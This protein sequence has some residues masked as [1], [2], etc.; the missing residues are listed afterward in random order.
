[1]T[2][3]EREIQ[4]GAEN[5][6]AR[7]RHCFVS[8]FFVAMLGVTADA[9]PVT[10][11]DPT[12]LPGAEFGTVALDGNH[13][14]IGARFVGQAH[15][16]DLT[17]NLLH[18]FDNP[19]VGGGGQFGQ[20]IAL[21]GNN[22]LIG[23]LGDSTFGFNFGQAHLFDALTGN[24]LWTFN[25]PNATVN[26]RFG[27]SVALN[28]NKALIGAPAGGG[29]PGQAHLFDVLSGNLLRT[30]DDPTG[31]PDDDRCGHFGSSVALDGNNVL[32]GVP[33]FCTI[34]PLH[35][36][37]QAHL[38]DALTGNLLHTFDDPT[39]GAPRSIPGDQFGGQLALDGNKV[40][41]GARFDDTHGENVGQ[42]HLFDGDPQ[43]PTFG[44]LLWTFD[45]PTPTTGDLFGS[46]ALDG[47]NILIGARD[48]D[49]NGT[50]VGQAHL[51]DGDPLSPT[52]GNLLRTFNDPTPT[53]SDI[54]G[55]QLAIEGNNVL[56]GAKRDDTNGTDAGQA[57][58]FSIAPG[59]YDDD[60]DVDGLDFL[61][62]Q[63]GESPNPLSQSDLAAW[64]ANYGTG[65]A[66]IQP[67]DFDGNGEVD[68]FDFLEWQRD[69][70]VGSLA[71]WEANYGIAV[72]L[73]AISA[74]VPEPTTSALALA[75]L[76]LAMSRRRSH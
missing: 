31:I 11:N 15:L 38:F 7:W 41:I 30:F 52:F 49:T 65:G 57:H 24:L 4:A 16:F 64:E 63:R 59:D 12:P 34:E 13:V 60:F 10:F 20:D 19:S 37:G 27:T 1:M 67:G 58:L 40:L 39:P 17:G 22:V 47:N 48:D 25:D 66:P 55:A 43:S 9:A 29:R 69:P 21:D 68:G 46:V 23:A 26:D 71:D 2:V 74:A 76:C 6:Y 32:I 70:S 62:W 33:G 18:T 8:A 53:T 75:A 54:F 51:F 56:I 50:N 45:D 14:L 72:T 28:G 35:L 5:D 3:R 42:A 73:S 61:K 44:D 36:V